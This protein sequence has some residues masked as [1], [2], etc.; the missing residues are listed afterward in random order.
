MF[1]S[2]G[3]EFYVSGLGIYVSG[4]EIYVSGPET[5]IAGP[6]IEITKLRNNYKLSTKLQKNQL[7]AFFFCF[8]SDLT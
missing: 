2:V 4:P 5:Y 7:I 8:L 3:K 6:A 1:I